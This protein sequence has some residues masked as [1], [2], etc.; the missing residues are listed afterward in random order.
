M[1]GPRLQEV[2]YSILLP[3]WRAGSDIGCII[4]DDRHDDKTGN[5]VTVGN[6]NMEIDVAS[7]NKWSQNFSK[8]NIRGIKA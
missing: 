8:P 5:V 3:V 2:G 7:I 6:G 1:G 4:Y